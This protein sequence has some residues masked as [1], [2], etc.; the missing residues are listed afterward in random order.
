MEHL[1]DGFVPLEGTLFGTLDR[2]FCAVRSNF[3]WNMT[4]FCCYKEHYLGHFIDNSLLSEEALRIG[5]KS[6]FGT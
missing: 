5:Q 4:V 1:T 2:L 6:F 3:V